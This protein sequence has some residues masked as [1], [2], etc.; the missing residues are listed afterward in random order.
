MEWKYSRS[1]FYMEFLRGPVLP[2]PFNLI[3][4][5]KVAYKLVKRFASYVLAKSRGHHPS[6][7]GHSAHT[8]NGNNKNMSSVSNDDFHIGDFIGSKIPNGHA[9]V[10]W[11]YF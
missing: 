3:P 2:T 11:S 10:P 7:N 9:K 8:S 4:K 1:K 6:A 5:P